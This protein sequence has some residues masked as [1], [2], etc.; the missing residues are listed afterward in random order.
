MSSA[1]GVS[2]LSYLG[3][4]DS[5]IYIQGSDKLDYP[6]QNV[7]EAMVTATM[8]EVNAGKVVVPAV[9]GHQI[10][11]SEYQINTTGTFNTLTDVRLQSSNGTPVVVVTALLAAIGGGTK[12]NSDSVITNVTDG[13]GFM[14]AL[15]AG[16]S[17]KIVKTGSDATTGTSI[18]V[19]VRYQIV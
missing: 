16:D 5:K 11:V 18:M 2:N 4:S 3:M 7:F 14:V 10:L 9:P 6:Q 17:L 13:A 12:I 19:R 1:N 8:A 15:G